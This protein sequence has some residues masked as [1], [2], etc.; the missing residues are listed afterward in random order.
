MADLPAEPLADFREHI[1]RATIPA[2]LNDREER[3][4]LGMRPEEDDANSF[5]VELNLQFNE[6]IERAAAA[7]EALYAS[8]VS[9][10]SPPERLS[11]TYVQC[12]MSLAEARCATLRSRRGGTRLSRSIR[13]SRAFVAFCDAWHLP[14]RSRRTRRLLRGTK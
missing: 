2:L 11:K 13:P 8:V 14:R 5:V 7:F 3:R 4:R 1:G 12:D 6:G 9:R 10:A